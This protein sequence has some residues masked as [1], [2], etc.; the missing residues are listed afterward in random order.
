MEGGDGKERSLD[1]DF[2][3]MARNL[4]DKGGLR[5]RGWRYEK[6]SGLITFKFVYKDAGGG[7]RG[8]HWFADDEELGLGIVKYGMDHSPED[9]S[10]EYEGLPE[11]DRKSLKQIHDEIFPKTGIDADKK[12]EADASNIDMETERKNQKK[13]KKKKK[14]PPQ[15]ETAPATDDAVAALP[16]VS[17]SPNL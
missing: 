9:P 10:I 5:E 16:R 11:K 12:R 17:M 15:V 3:S 4:W 13:K 1:Y 2:D 7:M 14:N 6:G 8:C